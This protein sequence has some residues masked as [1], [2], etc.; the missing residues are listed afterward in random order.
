MLKTWQNR[1]NSQGEKLKD[2]V[3][4][5]T[6]QKIWDYLKEHKTPITAGTMAK[7]FIISQSKSYQT[8]AELFEMAFDALVPFANM[9]RITDE[10]TQDDLR[11]ARETLRFISTRITAKTIASKRK[12]S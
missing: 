6:E 10:I 9:G 7:R 12:K 8:L 11:Q 3:L 2:P 1:L 4:T 5:P